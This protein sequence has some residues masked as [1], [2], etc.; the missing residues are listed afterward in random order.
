MTGSLGNTQQRHAFF[1][2]F[3]S[4]AANG[5]EIAR[6]L[7]VLLEGWPDNRELLRAIRDAEHEGDRLTYEVVNLLNNSFETPF[8]RDDMYRLATALDDI[9]DHVEE[10]AD[11]IDAYEVRQVPAL[12]LEQARVVE[13]AAVHLLE[14]MRML[15]GPEDPR[16]QLIAVRE[17]EDEGDRL[18]REA[19]AGLFRSGL[20]AL[21]IIRWK[22]IHE[23]IEEAVDACEN[24]AD[25]L[26]AILV[27]NL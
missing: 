3:R 16:S 2:R 5:A 7:V 10:A 20:D 17:L 27:K 4:A 23:Q 15:E 1:D 24:V 26:E 14:A 11:D 9:C 25:V 8:D 19:V 18:S 6:L 22:D 13:R 12:A 21:T